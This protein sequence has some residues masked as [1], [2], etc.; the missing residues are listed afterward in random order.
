[1]GGNEGEVSLLFLEGEGWG[2]GDF[3]PFAIFSVET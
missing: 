3:K 2:E 1:M